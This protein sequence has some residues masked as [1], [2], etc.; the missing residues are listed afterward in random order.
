MK[1]LTDGEK[2]MIIRAIIIGTGF[3]LT[4]WFMAWANSY[5]V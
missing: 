3:L 1:K 4:V 2:G 5:P